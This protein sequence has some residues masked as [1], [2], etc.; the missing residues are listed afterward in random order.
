MGVGL[1]VRTGLGEGARGNRSLQGAGLTRQQ[2]SGGRRCPLWLV[3]PQELQEFELGHG[4]VA[5]DV[6]CREKLVDIGHFCQY[7]YVARFL[8]TELRRTTK[9]K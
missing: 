4:I 6:A 8:Q 5:I 1:G 9:T 3:V 2:G 7:G